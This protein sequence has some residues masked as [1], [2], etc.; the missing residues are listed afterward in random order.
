[1][2]DPS[3]LEVEVALDKLFHEGDGFGFS[4]MLFDAFGQVGAAELGDDV[5][6]V[7]GGEDVMDIKDA[8]DVP[9]FLEDIDF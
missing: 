4:E 5:G 2:D 8:G 3:L 7:F 6:V 1:V 9:E